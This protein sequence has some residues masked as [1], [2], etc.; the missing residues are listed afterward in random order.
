MAK[1][2]TFGAPAVCLG[3]ETTDLA[4]ET[5]V[6]HDGGDG[7]FDG[8][9]VVAM[10][11]DGAHDLVTSSVLRRET[12]SYHIRT[13]VLKAFSHNLTTR[14][15]SVPHLGYMEYW[16]P[17]GSEANPVLAPVPNG[18]RDGC[19]S[20]THSFKFTLACHTSLY[21]FQYDYN[22]VDTYWASFVPNSLRADVGL[23]SA[24]QRMASAAVEGFVAPHE[25]ASDS[26]YR[27]IGAS[28]FSH[29][30]ACRE[31]CTDV[32]RLY[33]DPETLECVLVFASAYP[34]CTVNDMVYSEELSLAPWCGYRDIHAGA[35][36]N[37][38]DHLK[39]QPYT[40]SIKAKLP[41]CASVQAVGHSMGGAHAQLFAACASR[42]TACGQLDPK[43]RRGCNVD[44]GLVTWD[45]E[46]PEAM[47]E[48]V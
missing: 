12:R 9:R 7:V 22:K 48:V 13:P 4:N 1:V 42:Y 31:E 45:W 14:E 19:G 43:I 29:P 23:L 44:H 32:A 36:W 35:V 17:L 38:R 16:W 11:P 24:Y 46:A 2:F 27:K 21:H 37:F 15:P 47:P 26:S 20:R 18:T 34:V 6:L 5:N 10:A 30:C 33:Q 41:R 3:V 39:S 28:A 40:A 25:V 8:I